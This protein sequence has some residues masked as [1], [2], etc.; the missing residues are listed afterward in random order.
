MMPTEHQPRLERFQS[1]P[2]SQTKSKTVGHD[3]RCGY[4]DVLG[5]ES[6][7]R[8]DNAL[9]QSSRSRPNYFLGWPASRAEA[10]S[11]QQQVLSQEDVQRK[12]SED[13]ICGSL[14]CGA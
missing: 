7:S 3:C 11:K 6:C 1:K 12:Q 5:Y 10:A 13:T 4:Q 9:R 8:S 2:G 14:L